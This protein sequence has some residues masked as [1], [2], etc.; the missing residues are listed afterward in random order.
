MADPVPPPPGGE[1]PRPP[2]PGSARLPAADATKERIAELA[3]GFAMGELDDASLR[4]FYD[5]L[6]ADGAAGPAAAAIAWQQLGTVTDLRAALSHTFQD[7]V[8][9]RLSKSGS[10]ERFSSAMRNRLGAG[11]PA[12]EPVTWPVMGVNLS[13][14]TLVMAV[15]V[16]VLVVALALAIGLRG[17]HAEPPGCRV[18]A[19][20][21][22]AQ[23][24]GLA[25]TPGTAIASGAQVAVQPGGQ[26][27]LAWPDGTRAVLAGPANA[28][29]QS[30]GLS[31]TGGTAWIAANGAFTC[32]LPDATLRAGA[33]SRSAVEVASFRGSFRSVVAVAHGSVSFGQGHAG[34][35]DGDHGDGER[36]LGEGTTAAVGGA[37][38]RWRSL[39]SGTVAPGVG[40]YVLDGANDWRLAATVTW[41]GADD[42]VRLGVKGADGGSLVDLT[43]VPGNASLALAV[44]TPAATPDAPAIA[45][46][47]AQTIRLDG[48]PLAAVPL[49]LSARAGQLTV[50]LAGKDLAVVDLPPAQSLTIDPP[51]WLGLTAVTAHTGPPPMPPQPVDAATWPET[52]LG[53]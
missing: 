11:R 36:T 33:G 30:G 38:L 4:E 12:L 16:A 48:P 9:H 2:A 15:L 37:P 31:L 53:W 51:G 41:K 14:R 46:G 7:T 3:A 49:E 39:A 22:D 45:A 44:A 43:L 29:I 20:Q 47:Q 26:L 50:R 10:S 34:H 18:A 21:G 13:R 6:R 27:T 42:H 8:R 35:G 52:S 1:R 40:S 17:A 24:S 19:V 23:L 28:V 25:L 32:G 5:F